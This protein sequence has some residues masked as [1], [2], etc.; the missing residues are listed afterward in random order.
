MN[1]KY[2]NLLRE[3]DWIPF[4]ASLSRHSPLLL[5]LQFPPLF[6]LIS[7]SFFSIFSNLWSHVEGAGALRRHRKESQRYTPLFDLFAFFFKQIFDDFLLIFF[8]R[9]FAFFLNRS[10]DQ[11][12]HLRSEADDLDH[13]RIWS[14]INSSIYLFFSSFERILCWFW[15]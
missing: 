4:L 13:Q 11:G 8:I 9:F 7:S 14:G 12:L 3:N 6:N 2:K 15:S 5:N 1:K 10:A